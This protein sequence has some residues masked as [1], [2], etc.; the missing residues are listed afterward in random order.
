MVKIEC[1]LCGECCRRSRDRVPLTTFDLIRIAKAY[2]LGKARSL[3]NFRIKLDYVGG[4]V[5]GWVPLP[6]LV[7]P[8]DYL[9]QNRCG[10]YPYRPLTCVSY[11]YRFEAAWTEDSSCYMI[12][13]L[14]QAKM[15][16]QNISVPRESLIASRLHDLALSATMYQFNSPIYDLDENRL[17]A[18]QRIGFKDLIDSGI[19]KSLV[20]KPSLEE[21]LEKVSKAYI[22]TEPFDE[23]L[24]SLHLGF[25]STIAINV[26]NPDFQTSNLKIM[27][28]LAPLHLIE[29]KRLKKMLKRFM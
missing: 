18:I 1:D 25:E 12:R 5:D 6:Y 14:L 9:D 16:N 20:Y 8:C 3:A 29:R 10:I 28:S 23:K 11:P 26:A 4:A 7:L 2:S 21:V 24:M 17:I 15:K 27:K 19:D 22:P 13:E